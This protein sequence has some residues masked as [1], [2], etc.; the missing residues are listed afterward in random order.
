MWDEHVVQQRGRRFDSV[1]WEWCT[2][3]VDAEKGAEEDG[4]GGG[5][6]RELN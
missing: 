1:A 2:A 4:G 5:E 6:E 3:V